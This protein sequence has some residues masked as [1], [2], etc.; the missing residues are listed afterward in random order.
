MASERVE[1]LSEKYEKA[2]KGKGTRRMR[3]EF[4]SWLSSMESESEGGSG[5]YGRQE[6]GRALSIIEK[7]DTL[8]SADEMRKY[9]STILHSGGRRADI[10]NKMMDAISEQEDPIEAMRVA[11]ELAAYVGQRPEPFPVDVEKKVAGYRKKSV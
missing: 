4:R 3:D 1:R 7:Y 10:K 11:K 6:F 5:A 8:A 2:K 9:L